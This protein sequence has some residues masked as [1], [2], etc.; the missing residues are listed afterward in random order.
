MTLYTKEIMDELYWLTDILRREKITDDIPIFVIFEK[1][2]F[3]VVNQSVTKDDKTILFNWV[4]D[5]LGYIFLDGEYV[6]K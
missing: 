3:G 6:K 1:I 5:Y 4:L 2:P